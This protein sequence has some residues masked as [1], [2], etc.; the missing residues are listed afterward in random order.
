MRRGGRDSGFDGEIVRLGVLVD[1]SGSAASADRERLAGVETFWAAVNTNGGI[2][3][4]FAV[5][6]VVIDHGG[7]A[8][9]AA[10]ALDEMADEI[11]GVALVSS[12][13]VDSL[14]PALETSGLLAVPSDPSAS[15]ESVPQLLLAGTP[16]EIQL[17]ATF[18]RFAAEGVSWCV[19]ADLT[20][21]GASV[22]GAVAPAAEIAGVSVAGVYDIATAELSAVVADAGCSHVFVE[23]SPIAAPAA[24]SF[25][26][27]GRTVV[28]R[29]V[30]LHGA[31]YAP[32][33]EVFLLDDGSE[34]RAEASAGMQRLLGDLAVV[35]SDADPDPRLRAGYAAQIQLAATIQA[36]FDQADVRRVRLAELVFELATIDMLGFA[37]DVD[38]STTPPRLAR[39]TR[40]FS[41]DP[42]GDELG[43]R[44]VDAAISSDADQLL[45][46]L[47]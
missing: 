20:P 31:E 3:G 42:S 6:L 38:R 23:T 12:S 17:L 40:W 30:V 34:W 39:Q 24:A 29:S 47:G 33:V 15:W 10:E 35:S 26:P 41:L 45:A 19:I 21:M 11:M 4:R 36:G 25:V 9:A 18:E 1:L 13:V 16:V 28:G 32:D 7:D 44:F 43:W 22:A 37:S 2:E 5:E 14:L 8:G 46:Q 27:E